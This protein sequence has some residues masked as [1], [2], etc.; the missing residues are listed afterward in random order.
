MWEAAIHN[1]RS[2]SPE[3]AF[4]TTGP[5]SG[6][7]WNRVLGSTGSATH[8]FKLQG[9]GMPVS[10]IR[11]I[12][13]GNKYTIVHK[14]GDHVAYAGVIQNRRFVE[15]GS[16]LAVRSN[17][18]RRAILGVR[19][20]FGVNEY[21]P[22]SGVLNV[23]NRSHAGAVRAI[24]LAAIK[25]N[26]VPGWELL[27]D[28]PPDGAGSFN[29]AWRHEEK[30]TTEHL[31]SQVEDDGAEIDFAPYLTG[32][33]DLR[34]S[35]RV[36]P[37]VTV[38]DPF[39]LAARAPGSIVMG[40]STEE[41]YVSQRTGLLGFGQGRGQDAISTFAPLTGDG[42]GDLPVMDSNEVFD[43][44]SDPTRLQQA[45]DTEFAR[46][47]N[48]VEQWNYGLFIGGVGPQMASPGSIHDLHVFGSSF[49]TD[50]SHPQRVISLSGDLGYTVKPGVQAYG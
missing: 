40:L 50:G 39:V 1:T 32:A 28:V 48:P 38:G 36:A 9:A 14:W 34:Y 25:S 4:K 31:L 29:A 10:L 24:I 22:S 47:R 8:M 11:E 5:L 12:T 26:T 43:D 13:R 45:T 44:I 16:V 27:I 37:Q 20:P 7:S 35:V 33:G 21:N 6:A 30:L 41:D 15:G 3:F 46:R 2:G 19:N 23:S 17:E 49:I 18:L 42:I